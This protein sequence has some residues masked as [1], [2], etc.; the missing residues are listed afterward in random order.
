P[1]TA[2]LR[3]TYHGDIRTL[4]IATLSAASRWIQMS[5][6][7]ELGRKNTQAR[8]TINAS[9]LRELQPVLDALRP[10]TR[11]PITVNGRASF[12]GSVFGQ[13]EEPSLRGH[14]ELEN[15]STDVGFAAEHQTVATAGNG[16]NQTQNIATAPRWVHWDSLVTDLSYTPSVLTL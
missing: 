7:G 9:S 1:V 5:A 2:H 10:G 15:F 16:G 6:S 12:N 13:L 3:S 8:V 14:L 11:V 4:E